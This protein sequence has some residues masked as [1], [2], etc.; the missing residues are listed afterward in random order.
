MQSIRKDLFEIF[1]GAVQALLGPE[2]SIKYAMIQRA[3]RPEFGDYQANFA[4]S[5]AKQRGE[6]PKAM[7][8]TVIKQV[9]EAEKDGLRV[10][11]KLENAGPGF[12]NITLTEEYLVRQLKAF[13]PEHYAGQA[14]HLGQIV[15]IDYGS[16]NIAKEM[17]VGHLRSTVIGDAI[18]RILT[19]AGYT[20]V[21]QSHLGDWGTQFGMLIEYMIEKDQL[22]NKLTEMKDLTKLYQNSKVSFDADPAFAD[23]ARERVVKL[24]SG[25]AETLAMWQHLVDI[26]VAYFASI[27]QRLGVL[28]T[29]EDDCGESFYNNMLTGIVSELIQAGIAEKSEGALVIYLDGFVDREKNPLPM[30]I[31][32]TDGGY[33]YSTTDL[34]AA[35][36]RLNHYKADRLIYVTDSRQE[37][38]FAMLFAAVKRTNW[39][40]NTVTFEHVPFGSVLGKDKKPFKTRSGENIRLAELID[41]AEARAYK[42]VDEKNPTAPEN[43]K[44]QIANTIGIGALKYADLSSE[45]TKDYVFDWDTQLSFDGNTAPYLQNAYVRIQ[46]IFRKGE[47]DP[48][49]YAKFV[50]DERTILIT[51]P[52]EHELSIHLLEF[53]EV[54]ARTVEDLLIHK[55]CTYLHQLAALFHR[56]YEHCKI[57]N[58]PDAATKES[59]LIFCIL[60]STTLKKG[61]NLLGVNVLEKM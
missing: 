51:D 4:M 23:R 12:I 25:D 17:H 60:V 46:S 27:Y 1:Q 21:R 10:F 34:A 16:A 3:G 33:L 13:N 49:H 61:L 8:E 48:A 53:H 30:L 43:E 52:I 29:R 9:A 14:E 6:N 31:Q 20:I 19:F 32:K 42:I 24:Q 7:A 2:S 5:L 50:G 54:V 45:R 18:T 28:L 37:Q 38:H 58:A 55:L 36:Y 56:F 26:S 44:K 35:K 57:L 59:R 47:I 15:V 40:K 41:E 22:A 39:A 11:A